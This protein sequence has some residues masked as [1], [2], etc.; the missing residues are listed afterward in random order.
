MPFSRGSS[1]PRDWTWV[2]HTAG[3]FFSVWT[4]REA[5]LT[6]WEFSPVCC[7]SPAVVWLLLLLLLTLCLTLVFLTR[8]PLWNFNT[9][10]ILY[11]NPCSIR[12]SVL[13]MLKGRDFWPPSHGQYLPLS[14]CYCSGLE[15]EI[16]ACTHWVCGERRGCPLDP[17]PASYRAGCWWG[18]HCRVRQPFPSGNLNFIKLFHSW[19][20]R[21]EEGIERMQFLPCLDRARKRW[22]GRDVHLTLFNGHRACSPGD[23]SVTEIWIV[24]CQLGLAAST[25]LSSAVWVVKKRHLSLAVIV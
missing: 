5:F 10:D 6:Q 15:G 24:S 9:T 13:Y 3:W 11:L 14:G 8:S 4:T 20:I 7:Y 2:S 23:F 25:C 18:I 17:V 16:T 22:A 19:S 1:W 21:R 12:K